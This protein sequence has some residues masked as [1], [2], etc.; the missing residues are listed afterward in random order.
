MFSF[1]LTTTTLSPHIMSHC[2]PPHSTGGSFRHFVWQA[3]RELQS[4]VLPIL[5]PCPSGATGLNS[6][7][8]HTSRD[9]HIILCVYLPAVISMS[10][11]KQKQAAL[12]PIPHTPYPIPHTPYLIP[13]TPYVYALQG[14]YILCPGQMSYSEEKLLQFFGQLVGVAIRAD[15]PIA[16]DLLPCFWKS[17]KGE[18]LSLADLRDADCITF[19]LTEKMLSVRTEGSVLMHSTLPCTQHR[20]S[21]YLLHTATI[22]FD[23]STVCFMHLLCIVCAGQAQHFRSDKM[24]ISF[25]QCSAIEEFDEL[26]A[27]LVRHPSQQQEGEAGGGV[28]YHTHHQ[29][30]QQGGVQFVYHTMTGEEVELCPDGHHKPLT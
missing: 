13:H 25:S 18:P 17:L 7:S 6:V 19:H 12:T 23:V 9:N 24:T 21:F 10:K 26:L 4:S 3:V 8:I 30:S 1:V 29:P 28:V 5:L 11:Q 27:G 22:C 15:V 14:K 2:F 20:F 16:L